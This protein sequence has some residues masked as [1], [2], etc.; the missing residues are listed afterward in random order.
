MTLRM[1]SAR[2]SDER[3]MRRAIKKASDGVLEGQTPFGACIVKAGRV[4]ACEHNRVWA[5]GDI[6]AHAEVNAIRTACR[7]LKSVDLSGC[8]VYSTCE[9]CPMCYAAC[10]WAK[11]GR[12]VYGASIADAMKAGFSEL[13]LSNLLMRRLG[14]RVKVTSGVLAGE[15]RRLLSGWSKRGGRTY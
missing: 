7:K 1:D 10:H 13:K 11:A 8:T 5:D 12:I 3:H 15:C 4:V 14:G 2:K 9:P 6:T